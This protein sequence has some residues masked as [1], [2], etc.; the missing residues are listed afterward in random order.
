MNTYRVYVCHNHDC[1]SRGAP[2]VW[3][4][5]QQAVAHHGLDQS[6]EL[7]VATCQ[8]RCEEGPNITVHP[9]A[10]KY[11][12]VSPAAALTI[13]E[14]HLAGDTIVAELLHAA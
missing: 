5:L 7:I 8:G 11:C 2:L 12:A 9:G 4:A 3:Q 1:R 10:T 6:V 14:Q 13:A